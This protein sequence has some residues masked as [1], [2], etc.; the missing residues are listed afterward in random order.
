MSLASIKADAGAIE[1][2]A[3]SA[4]G[5]AGHIKV[6]RAPAAPG[7]ITLSSSASVIFGVTFAAAGP[8]TQILVKLAQRGWG[9]T[10]DGGLL[11]VGLAAALTRRGAALMEDAA[12]HPTELAACWRDCM[13]SI[14]AAL[15]EESCPITRR[16]KLS[17]L[18]AMKSVVATIL[19]AKPAAMLDPATDIGRLSTLILDA[20]LSSLDPV[21]AKPMVKLLPIEGGTASES[22]SEPQA[23][24]LD[25]PVPTGCWNSIPEWRSGAEVVSRPSRVAVYDCRIQGLADPTP[26]VMLAPMQIDSAEQTLHTPAQAEQAMAIRFAD[27]CVALKISVVASQKTIHGSFKRALL[28]CGV[29][30]LER[31][32]LRYIRSVVCLSDS[33]TLGHCTE[34]IPVRA[35]GEVRGLWRQRIGRRAYLRMQGS[36]NVPRPVSTLIIRAET[37]HS[38]DELQRVVE[39]AL[40]AI[41]RLFNQPVVLLG[42]G[43]LEGFAAAIARD[44]GHFDPRPLAMADALGSFAARLEDAAAGNTSSAHKGDAELELQTLDV[45]STRLSAMEAAVDAASACIRMVGITKS[46][47]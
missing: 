32:S 13:S 45:L 33:Q 6:S 5:P 22:C 36:E 38:L 28:D 3:L 11:A 31:L 39:S 4:Y 34:R 2:L 43:R 15:R 40:D 26:G 9:G 30:P 37:R 25:V 23:I 8:V 12:A 18:V 42:G 20:T 44:R 24:F 7:H 19:Q 21:G 29:L 47:R 1:Q 16:I 17:D 10:R 41:P 46:S 14:R 27:A 35:L